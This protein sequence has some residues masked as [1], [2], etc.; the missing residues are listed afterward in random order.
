MGEIVAGYASS[1]AFTSSRPAGGKASAQRTGRSTHCDAVRPHLA[2]QRKT[3]NHS[4]P[5]R[6]ATRKLRTGFNGCVTAL[7]KTDWI[8]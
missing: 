8:A 5:L 3:K 4:T 1:H 6:R 7:D 2:R